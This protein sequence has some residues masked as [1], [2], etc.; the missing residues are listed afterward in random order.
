MPREKE[1]TMLNGITLKDLIRGEGMY[2]L[3]I[4]CSDILDINEYGFPVLKEDFDAY[5]EAHRVKAAK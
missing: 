3:N 5:V 2:G 4:S 1:K